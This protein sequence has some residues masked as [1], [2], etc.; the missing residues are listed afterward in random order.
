[1]LIL[2]SLVELESSLREFNPSVKTPRNKKSKNPLAIISI[3]IKEIGITCF[4]TFDVGLLQ[5][6]F[7]I[8]YMT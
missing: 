6:L 4:K 2:D 1:M 3:K 5:D 8:V 7:L